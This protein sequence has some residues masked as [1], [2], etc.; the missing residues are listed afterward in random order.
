M[1]K[2]GIPLFSNP[3]S[4]FAAFGLKRASHSF[5]IAPTA[6]PRH[7]VYAPH[8]CF[9]AAKVPGPEDGLVLLSAHLVS[10]GSLDLLD[11]TR[12]VQVSI[13]RAQSS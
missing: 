2:L 5:P 4:A 13:S 1:P 8:H 9:A 10:S 11:A 7:E 3:L 6:H 12:I